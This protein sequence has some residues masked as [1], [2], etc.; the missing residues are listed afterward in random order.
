MK[1]V[2]QKVIQIID[3]SLLRKDA[4]IVAIDGRCAAGKTT[5]AAQLQAHYG[6]NVVHMD[7]FF[8]RPEQRTPERLQTPGE[9]VDHERFLAEVLLPL[10]RGEQV[11]YRP[12]R[13]DTQTMAAPITLTG[14]RLTIV[15]GS[16]SFH[17][18][19]RELYDLRIFLQVDPQTQMERIRR[20]NGAEMAKVFQNRWIPLEEAYFSTCQVQSCAQLCLATDTKGETME[21]N[22]YFKS[23]ID[24][25]PRQVVI[26][27]TD[28]VIRYMNP[29]AVSH[30]ETRGGSSL[31]GKSLMDCHNARSVAAIEQV[32]QWFGKSRENNRVHTFYNAK[33]NRDVYMIALRSDDGTLIGYYEQHIIRNPDPTPLY[34]M[35]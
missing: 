28:H 35:D 21:L 30:Y 33:D 3:E 29:A 1:S 7:E 34:Q 12:F 25:D 8:L 14:H 17:K 26:C 9:N 19:L 2:L 18:D 5:L 22:P 10:S 4:L 11:T 27:D 23:I 32:V 20:R 15:E 24:Q 13:C 31:V 16:Y 6:C